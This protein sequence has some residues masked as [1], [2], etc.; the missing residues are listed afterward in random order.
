MRISLVTIRHSNRRVFN[1]IS[2]SNGRATIICQVG[3]LDNREPT[4][5]NWLIFVILLPER[6]AQH[7]VGMPNHGRVRNRGDALFR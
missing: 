3:H 5:H 1:T 7:V 2:H 6:V 4:T